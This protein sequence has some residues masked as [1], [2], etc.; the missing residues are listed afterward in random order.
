M[1][2][3]RKTKEKVK[4]D[5]EAKGLTVVGAERAVSLN[6]ADVPLSNKQTNKA[7]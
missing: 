4:K 5:C 2:K 7:R 6:S 3:K 1:Q